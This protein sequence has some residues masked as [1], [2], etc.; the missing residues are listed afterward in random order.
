MAQWT[1]ENFTCP[2][3]RGRRVQELEQ[4]IEDLA[5]DMYALR[6]NLNRSLE[7]IGVHRDRQVKAAGGTHV[8]SARVQGMNGQL[9]IRFGWRDRRTRKYTTRSRILDVDRASAAWLIGLPD[10]EREEILTLDRHRRILNQQYRIT[11]TER[12][13]LLQFHQEEQDLQAALDRP[14]D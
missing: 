9:A 4:A 6:S 13:S 3:R 7:R 11:W 5:A 10:P 14:Q 8:V 2:D 1:D 12:Q